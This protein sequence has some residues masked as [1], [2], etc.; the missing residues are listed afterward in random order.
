MAEHMKI[1]VKDE[2]NVIVTVGEST[3]VFN[4][5]EDDNITVNNEIPDEWGISENC[6]KSQVEYALEHP[7]EERDDDHM[8]SEPY[9]IQL[10]MIQVKES[11]DF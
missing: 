11:D 4:I 6:V 7:P 10:E 8:W 2:N 3:V 5:D 1:V 9:T